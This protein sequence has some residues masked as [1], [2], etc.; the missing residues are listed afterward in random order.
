M[1]QV[2]RGFKAASLGIPES[3][4]YTRGGG[5]YRPYRGRGRGRGAFFRGAGRGPPRGSMKLDNRPKKLLVK[6]VREGAVSALREWYEV[7]LVCQRSVTEHS[8]ISL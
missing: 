4:E 1:T 7:R 8:S 2:L 6:G 5:S 3:A